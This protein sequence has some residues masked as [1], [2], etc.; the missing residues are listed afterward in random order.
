LPP[1]RTCFI[2]LLRDPEEASGVARELEGLLTPKARPQV[3]VG[4]PEWEDPQGN[5]HLILGG[6]FFSTDAEVQAKV[7]AWWA[8][9]PP[10]ATNVFVLNHEPGLVQALSYADG[11]FY[12]ALPSAEP[13][14]LS[15]YAAVPS[16]TTYFPTTSIDHL[17]IVISAFPENFEYLEGLL[18]SGPTPNAPPEDRAS[19]IQTLDS[20][21]VALTG[22]PRGER[23]RRPMDMGDEDDEMGTPRRRP[24]RRAAPGP[25]GPAPGYPDAGGYPMPAGY[26]APAASA[27]PF[28]GTPASVPAPTPLVEPSTP[29]PFELLTADSAPLR[30]G[31]G[32]AVR[33]GSAEAAPSPFGAP[34]APS[35]KAPGRRIGLPHLPSLP[36]GL[37]A[38]P[39]LHSAGPSVSDQDLA[40]MVRSR[41]GFTVAIGSR[42][43]G[44]GKTT[45]AAAVAVGLGRLVNMSGGWAAIMDFNVVNPG[46]WGELE[47]PPGA[48]TVR[49]LITALVADREPPRP[50]YVNS[51]G[52]VLYPYGN[53]ST[54]ST[55]TEVDLVAEYNRRQWGAVVID[56]ANRLPGLGD[57]AGEV[58]AYWMEH[59]D[60]LVL[61][62]TANPE[63]L[64]AVLDYLAVENL[65]PTVVAYIV[66]GSRK[67]RDHPTAR[68]FLEEIAAKVFAVV[69]IPDDKGDDLKRLKL[70]GRPINEAP[71]KFGRAYRSLIE[72]ILQVPPRSRG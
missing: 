24:Q 70:E 53:D 20:L 57:P 47:L 34:P 72:A 42:K 18:G 52:L 62:T 23:R 9:L 36:G 31:L 54:E 55:S 33:S 44:V 28:P 64:V 50:G 67:V 7:D 10:E 39:R 69:E 1:E 65:P 8:G 45:T 56:T 48:A 40:R 51:P 12:V 25:M 59:A 4:I 68:R 6:D 35:P 11:R 66:S 63:D 61:P 26:P 46:D 22:E 30:G 5:H 38:M 43:G 14:T 17:Q 16:V 27:R 41:I 2:I 13:A 49:Q 15:E 32:P 19:L 29:H 60:C 3:T 71:A 37:P 58:V 21:G